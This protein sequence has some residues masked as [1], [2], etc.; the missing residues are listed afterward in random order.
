VINKSQFFN[1]SDNTLF[2]EYQKR[3]LAIGTQFKVLSDQSAGLHGQDSIAKREEMANLSKE[4]RTTA[5]ISVNNIRNTCSP[6][7]SP[8]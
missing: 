4:I 2:S 5:K 7:S 8:C 1:S 6:P 3:S